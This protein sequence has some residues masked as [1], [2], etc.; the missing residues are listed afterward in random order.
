MTVPKT[1]V[2]KGANPKITSPVRGQVSRPQ[3]GALKKKVIKGRGQ[4]PRPTQRH[5][6]MSVPRF[7]DEMVVPLKRVML[8]HSPKFLFTPEDVEAL[9]EET[10]LLK[11]QILKWADHFRDRWGSKTQD[12]TLDFLRGIEKVT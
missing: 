8:A 9:V 5:A 11:G 4:A 12:E 6:T 7:T 10:G 1:G 3:R 2:E